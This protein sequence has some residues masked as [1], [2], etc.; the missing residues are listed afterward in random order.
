MTQVSTL[1]GILLLFAFSIFALDATKVEGLII[2]DDFEVTE[3]EGG[4]R[5]LEIGS[6]K[7]VHISSEGL[8]KGISAKSQFPMAIMVDKRNERLTF[9]IGSTIVRTNRCTQIRSAI[10]QEVDFYGS[11]SSL[12]FGVL[13]ETKKDV[14]VINEDLS[15]T[16][17]GQKFILV[18]SDSSSMGLTGE[19]RARAK[20][21]LKRAQEARERK[22]EQ[23]LRKQEEKAL[24]KKITRSIIDDLFHGGGFQIGRDIETHYDGYTFTYTA[25][26][27]IGT[28]GS[29]KLLTLY[30]VREVRRVADYR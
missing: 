3:H 2:F 22:N 1:L 26:E 17:A 13:F 30:N 12:C 18:K 6:Q 15:L 4:L 29:G 11:N 5:I 10:V 24:K 19:K 23:K 20:K 9:Y 8:L 16:V 28:D 25:G 7:S 27:L 14:V 21:K